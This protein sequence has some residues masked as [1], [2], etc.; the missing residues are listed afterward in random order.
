MD[1]KEKMTIAKGNLEKTLKMNAL[2]ENKRHL[3]II[4]PM[5]KTQRHNMN[6]FL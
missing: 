6:G 5:I 2:G 4:F 1:Y 3:V